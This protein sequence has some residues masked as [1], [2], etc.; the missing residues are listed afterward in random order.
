MEGLQSWVIT[1][2]VVLAAMFLMAKRGGLGRSG[3]RKPTRPGGDIMVQW[4]HGPSGQ[5]TP[6]PWMTG[7]EIT[8]VLAAITCGGKEALLVSIFVLD[9]ILKREISDVDIATQET[10]DRVLALVEEAGIKGVPTGLKHG[11]VTAVVGGKSYEITTLRSDIETDG[12]HAVVAFTEDWRKDAARRDF[13]FNAMSATPSGMVYDYYN[14]MQDLADRVIR[15]VGPGKQRI[16]ED[17]LRALRYFRFIATLDMRIENR[18]DLDACIT[19]APQLKDL[20]GE[21][22]RDELFKI[23]IAPKHIRAL[24][25]MRDY[26]VME[27]IL[28]EA[29]NLERLSKMV[30]LETTAINFA[31]VRPDTLRR[32]AVL[33]DTDEAGAARACARLRLSGTE[34]KRLAALVTPV[35][36]PN[37]EMSMDDLRRAFYLYSAERVRDFILLEWTARLAIDPRRPREETEVWQEMLGASEVWEDVSFPLQG[38]DALALGLQAGPR[39]SQVLGAV[40]EWWIEGGCRA[41]HESC[42]ER[43]RALLEHET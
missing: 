9:S 26:G 42:L 23:L 33:L 12:R 15:F 2:L 22:I 24:R 6:A 5:L 31:S 27:Q 18:I 41:G 10:S 11:T 19:A 29:G 36:Q 43:L 13:S 17:Y 37:P 28:P 3:R 7:P 40:E 39:I 16:A 38:R 35:W 30:W 1:I 25:L 14:G 4:E 20:S 8:A 34:T 32:L 21:R